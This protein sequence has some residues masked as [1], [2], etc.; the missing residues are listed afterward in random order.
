[1][2][3]RS[4]GITTLRDISDLRRLSSEPPED[5]HHPSPNPDPIVRRSK[6]KG[7]A[8]LTEVFDEGP[9]GGDPEGDP[10]PPG[11]PGDDE[12]PQD[13]PDNN[14]E[15]PEDEAFMRQV[16]M[17]LAK[18]RQP[19]ARAKVK[20]PDAYDGSNQAKLRTYFLQCMLN[21]RDRP[22]AFKT[23][24]AKVQYAISY[25]T[26]T[27]LVHCE[28]A[29][30]GEIIP[31]PAWLNNW[32]LFK[33]ELEFNFGHFNNAAQAEIE[34]EKIVMKEHHKAA[35]YFIDFTTASTRTGW[36]DA[37][38][39]HAAYKGLAK[40]I[41]DD[42]LHFP[43]FQS[44]TELRQFALECDSR[45]W[46]RKD[47]DAMANARSPQTSNRSNNQSGNANQSSSGS[48]KD[49]N[50]NKGNNNSTPKGSANNSTPQRNTP[51]I[52]SKLGKDGKLTPEE[53]QRRFD[54]GL[55]MLCGTKGHMVKDC[56]KASNKSNSSGSKGRSAKTS[57]SKTEAT[58][59]STSEPKK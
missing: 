51:D 27:A 6:G 17:S 25:L 9:S 48:N 46:E 24:S 57:D 55:C 44:F 41:K 43:R 47:Y 45:Y 56:P 54:Q 16:L 12:S 22:S 19:E 31:E 50:R 5:I 3:T 58:T 7:R 38:L 10:N 37:A 20:E 33:A 13:N 26:G 36:N 2:R 52:S 42:L 59:A 28:P 49:K 15:I 30:L 4:Q 8:F 40:R 29:I 39:R 53:R 1:M 14:P 35:R 23:G 32:D 21:F 34:L 11:D 18:P